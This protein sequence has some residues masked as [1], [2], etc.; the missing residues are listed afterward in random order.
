[1]RQY[2]FSPLFRSAIGFDRL[3]SMMETA[4]RSG[5]RADGY[6]PYNIEKL[7][8]DE[9]RITIAVAGFGPDDI[10]VEVRDGTLLVKGKGAE[11]RPEIAYLHRGIAGR[12]FERRF[13]IADHVEVRGANLANGLLVIEL[14]RELPEAMKPRRIEIAIGGAT[15]EHKSAA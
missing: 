6:P 4:M 13:Q 15:I 1:M 10:E 3:P 2:D 14:V 9:Y 12:A 5:A 11:E 8:Q 7:G